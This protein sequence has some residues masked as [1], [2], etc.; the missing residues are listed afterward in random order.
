MLLVLYCHMWLF[1][2]VVIVSSIVQCWSVSKSQSFFSLLVPFFCYLYHIPVFNH[3][4]H[5]IATFCC[6]INQL[7][8]I[9]QSNLTSVDIFRHLLHA[10]NADMHCLDGCMNISRSRLTPELY[11]YHCESSL[12]HKCQ[13]YIPSEWKWTETKYCLQFQDCQRLWFHHRVYDILCPFNLT[14]YL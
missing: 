4:M 9:N 2:S 11:C 3:W 14:G 8:R 5:L 10:P 7:F 13:K 12:I 6:K 1:M